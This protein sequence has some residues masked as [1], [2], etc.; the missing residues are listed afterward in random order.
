MEMAIN[1]AKKGMGY[2]N[3]NP[4]VGCVVVKN[5]KIVATGYHK[6]YGEYHAERNAL[7][8]CT[9]DLTNATLYVTLEPCCHYGKTPPCT[10]IIVEKG[11]K[12][13][14]IGTLDNNSLVSGKGIEYL[15]Q[16]GINVITGV[17]EEDCKKLNE[18][19]FHFISKKVPFVIMKYAMSADGKI[20]TYTGDSKWITSE[21]TREYVHQTRAK[22][23]SI[24]VGIETVL[25]DNPTLNLRY[26][27]KGKNPIRIIC[28]SNLKIP[29]D[30]NIVKTAK[31]IETYVACT[32]NAPKDKIEKLEKENIKIIST[33]PCNNRVNLKEL[34]IKLG[35][36]NIDSILLEGGGT[37]NFSFLENNLVDKV[38][39]Y[40]APKILGGSLAKT[41]VEGLGVPKV[42]NSFNLVLENIKTFEKDLLLEYKVIK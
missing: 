37:L 12:E 38:H 42:D 40:I 23:A 14:V 4:M 34:L 21:D 19:F 28:D 7:I 11:I 13:V 1:L 32:N 24:L 26:N 20:C 16:N 8:D 27:I 3:P 6:A 29:L 35:S 22:V 41:A 25:K 33:T 15:K 18:I 2:V 9:E 10:E 30:S 31:E 36:L 17:L 5:D 39:C